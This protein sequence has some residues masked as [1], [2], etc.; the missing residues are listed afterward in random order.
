MTVSPMPDGVV[1]LPDKWL[2]VEKDD[3][4]VG[5]RPIPQAVGGGAGAVA[6]PPAFSAAT[7]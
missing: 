4:M 2:S 5:Q 6:L 1:T 7:V 3:I